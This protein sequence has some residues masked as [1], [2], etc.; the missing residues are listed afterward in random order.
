MLDT[1]KLALLH[2]LEIYKKY[3]DCDHPLKQ[4]D[5]IARLSRDYGIDL[6]RKAVGRNIALLKEAGVEICSGRNGSYLLSRAFEDSELKMLIDG[7]LSSKYITAKHSKELIQKL[8]LQSNVYFRPRVKYVYSVGDWNKTDNC[9][10]FYNIDIIDEAIERKLKIKFTYNK[11]GTDKILHRSS[12]PTVS[13]YQLILKN[14]RYFLMAFEEKHREMTFYRMDHIT[15]IEL[16]DETA[17]ELRSV[18]GYRNGI[19]FKKLSSTMPY[20][21]SDGTERVEFLMIRH[22]IDQAVEWFGYGAEISDYDEKRVKVS[23]TVSPAAMEYW[24]M[25]FL[26]YVEVVSPL[27]LRE[28]IKENLQNASEKYQ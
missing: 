26:N 10:L 9:T 11:Y 8:C 27:S 3:S 20:M 4:E 17:T 6:E 1:K 23:V 28:K 19:D 21:Y 18:E 12:A 15:D 22:K 2:I 14:Q 7:V 13:P 24:A 16:L 25:Q 5:I